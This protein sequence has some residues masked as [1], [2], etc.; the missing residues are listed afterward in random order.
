MTYHIDPLSEE[1]LDVFALLDEGIYDFEVTKSEDGMSKSNN[2]MN[3][4][5]LKIWKP[6]GSLK[7]MKDYLVFS[8]VNFCIRKI[9]HF[10]DAVGIL[11]EFEKGEIRKDFSGL[12]G[13]LELIIKEGGLIPEDKLDGKPSGSKYPTKNEVKDY[14]LK[15]KGA[16]KHEGMKPLPTSI[17]NFD[18]AE[19]PF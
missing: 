8:S 7:I 6:D 4:I 10:C 18:D 9:R 1:E 16:V 15:D 2:P 11:G 12:A 17:D 19:L 13:K 3:T 14:V 5:H